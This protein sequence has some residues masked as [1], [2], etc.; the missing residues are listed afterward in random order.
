[1]PKAK[2]QSPFSAKKK[3]LRPSPPVKPR[4]LDVRVREYL[5][6]NEV[7]RLKEAAAKASRHGFRDS[8][9]ISMTYRHAFRVGEVIDLRWDQVDFK[10]GRLHVNRLKNGDPSVHYLEGDELRALRQLKR[11]YPE[12]D[13]VFASQRQGPLSARSVH[14]IVAKAGEFAGISFPVHPHML[15]HA[16]GYQL[17]SRG[18]DTRAIQGYFGH[19]NI[20]HTVLYTK[21]D[22]K[23]FKGFGRD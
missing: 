6:P 10:A 9:L 4:N 14:N 16:K 20:Q 19:K 12:S 13:F 2:R 18:E 1:M 21:L 3:K 22:P 7:K 23:R 17:A 11:D 8:L 5:T 15:R